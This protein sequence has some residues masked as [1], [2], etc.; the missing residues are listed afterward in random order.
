MTCAQPRGFPFFVIVVA[1]GNNH[2]VQIFSKAGRVVRVF[3]RG[4]AVPERDGGGRGGQHHSRGL[5]QFFDGLVD[6]AANA[7]S[8]LY[9][10]LSAYSSRRTPCL[11]Q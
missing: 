2:L 7:L 1:D 9:S 10:E 6:P 5:V 8:G 11:F 3:G 4:G